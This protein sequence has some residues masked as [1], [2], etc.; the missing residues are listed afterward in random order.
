LQRGVAEEQNSMIKRIIYLLAGE[1]LALKR[2]L[3]LV[4][5]KLLKIKADTEKLTE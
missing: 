5:R 2:K 1:Y 4:D 3:R